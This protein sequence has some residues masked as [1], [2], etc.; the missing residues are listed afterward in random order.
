MVH[1]DRSQPQKTKTR[2]S[3]PAYKNKNHTQ[4]YSFKR[5]LEMDF[6]S[7]ISH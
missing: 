7:S 4:Y 6:Y 5:K 3:K 1:Y 2:Q